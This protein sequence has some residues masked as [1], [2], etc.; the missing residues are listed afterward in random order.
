[1]LENYVGISHH[2]KE[3]LQKSK[4]KDLYNIGSC[5]LH[6]AHKAYLKDTQVLNL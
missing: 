6:A 4:N 5:L 2:L 1:M 3:E